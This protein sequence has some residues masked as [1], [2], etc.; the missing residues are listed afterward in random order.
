MEMDDNYQFSMKNRFFYLISKNDTFYY[1]KFLCWCVGLYINILTFLYLELS[2]YESLDLRK[3]RPVR[4]DDLIKYSSLGFGII[5][6]V[7]FLIWLTFRGTIQY[8]TAK[9]DLNEEDPYGNHNNWWTKMK[10]W[11]ITFK[12]DP[13]AV[14]FFFHA[15]FAYLGAF[16]SPF[17]HTLHL[18][19]LVN[20]SETAK[21]VFNA[22]AAHMDQL[23]VTLILAF[24]LIYSFSVLNANYYSGS[25][26]SQSVGTL[27]TCQT[28]RSC[29]LYVVN[30]GLRNGG[31][32]GDAQSLYEYSSKAIIKTFFDLIFFFLINVISLNIIFGIII[33]TFSE[34]RG[35]AENRG[36]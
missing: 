10:L 2:E 32:I 4:F 15:V 19:L 35:N 1:L 27:D 8:K 20:I 5:T 9:F 22:S 16:V 29:F 6:S 34:L 3:L 36:K 26:D 28:L 23:L 13:S 7:L 33:D 14:N 11:L 12:K 24:F 18:L 25:F 31:G 30:L 17:F 21:Y